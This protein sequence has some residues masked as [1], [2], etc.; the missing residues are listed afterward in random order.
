MSSSPE[1]GY[2][3]REG[4]NHKLT[5]CV[6]SGFLVADA[7]V[8][9]LV[10][11]TSWGSALGVGGW[12]GTSEGWGTQ[13]REGDT[14]RQRSGFSW[15]TWPQLE[16][17]GSSRVMGSSAPQSCPALTPWLPTPGFGLWWNGFRTKL[18]ESHPV[19]QRE[20]TPTCGIQHRL[21]TCNV[22]GWLGTPHLPLLPTQEGVCSSR[23]SRPGNSEAVL[24]RRVL[25][26]TMSR[27]ATDWMLN[28]LKG[29][30]A[31]H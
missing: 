1:P 20:S 15:R 27:L 9:I 23:N 21:Y 26:G 29:F 4:W 3:V 24:V 19:Q 28:P 14:T 6:R 10:L 2:T 25:L 18:R 8:A 22:G 7:K 16:Y 11:M 13:L 5:G 31:K 17:L 12:G 30:W